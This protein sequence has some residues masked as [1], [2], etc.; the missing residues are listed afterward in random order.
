MCVCA[1]AYVVM[2]IRCGA[3]S[4][5]LLLLCVCVCTHTQVC[6]EM[7]RTHNKCVVLSFCSSN[8][9][10]CFGVCVSVPKCMESMDVCET[11]L[12]QCTHAYASNNIPAQVRRCVCVCALT[13]LQY[14]CVT[15]SPV[16]CVKSPSPHDR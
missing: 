13:C 10:V 1:C 8:P 11:V 5:L 7:Q 12:S 14:V 4:V 15:T 6:F 9:V 16:S 3:C 2:K